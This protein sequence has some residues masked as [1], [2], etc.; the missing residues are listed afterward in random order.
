MVRVPAGRVLTVPGGDL[1]FAATG[2]AASFL[3][4]TGGFGSFGKNT[5]SGELL[6]TAS[7]GSRL[8]AMVFERMR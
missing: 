6:E 8:W 1:G 5:I 2:A 3:S 7:L 4:C